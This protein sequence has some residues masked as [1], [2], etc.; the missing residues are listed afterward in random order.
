M[1][2]IGRDAQVVGFPKAK[3]A[4]QGSQLLWSS[5][6][7][8]VVVVRTAAVSDGAGTAAPNVLAI[9]AAGPAA[10]ATAAL[11]LQLLHC[12]SQLHRLL[13]LYVNIS[14]TTESTEC[15]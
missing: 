11:K 14:A 7:A 9:A 1:F 2:V 4:P 10:A 15:Y 13:L 3:W 12:S 6:T 5:Q 8:T